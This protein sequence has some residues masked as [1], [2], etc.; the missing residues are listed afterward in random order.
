VSDPDLVARGQALAERLAKFDAG[1]YPASDID[2][3]EVPLPP[4][5]ESDE[6][7]RFKRDQP[8]N[9]HHFVD[10]SKVAAHQRY[11]LLDWHRLFAGAPDDVDWLVPDVCAR[12]RSYSLN[13]RAKQGKSLFMLDQ[14]AAGAFS[15]LYV[16]CENSHDDLVER[17]EDM[18]YSAADLVGRVHYLS[19]PNLPPL[20]G[21]VGAAD[22]VELADHYDVDL[23]VLDTL[24]RV[25]AGEENS[26]DTI[27]ALYRHAIV[28][29]K[30]KRR[31]VVRLDHLGKDKT[32]HKRARGISKERRCIWGV[33]SHGA[34]RQ[35]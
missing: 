6:G 23:V 29:L 11:P 31:T 35:W 12:G 7:S 18:G 15:T 20:D 30:A 27:K 8:R 21:P 22:L 1:D 5:P 4:E 13:S 26:S 33:E 3:S 28:P 17:L 16:D 14:V 24:S 34:Q 9:S 10:S 25:V 2:W 19:F 32:A